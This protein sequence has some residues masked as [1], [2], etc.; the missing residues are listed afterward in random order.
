MTS[1]FDGKEFQ[2]EEKV[3]Q[4]PV[5]LF[6]LAMSRSFDAVMITTAEKGYPIIFI[7]DAFTQ[8]TGYSQQECVG[9]SPSFLQGSKTDRAVLQRL[10][11][12]LENGAPFHGEAVNYRKNGEEFVMEWRVIPYTGSQGKVT[13]YIAIQRDITLLRRTK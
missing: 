9:R 5:G 7:N 10:K 6:A 11:E 3:G 12:N 13:H 4:M 8:I 2:L 1:P